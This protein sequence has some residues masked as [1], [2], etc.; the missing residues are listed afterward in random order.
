MLDFPLRRMRSFSI[1]TCFSD[2]AIN[3]ALR[4]LTGYLRPTPMYNFPI[5]A[6]IKPAELRRKGA[7]LS[8]AQGS[9]SLDIC[10]TQHSPA[11]RVGMHGITNRDTHFYPPHNN[12]SVHLTTTSEVRRSGW[13]TDGMRSGWTTPRE[14]ALS[15]PTPT[16]LEWPSEEQRG[17]SLSA[18]APESDISSPACTTGVLRPLR[19]VNVVQKNKPSTMLYSNVQSIDPLMDCTAWRFWMMR[20]S[21]SCSPLPRDIVRPSSGQQQLAQT[22]KK[23]KLTTNVRTIRYS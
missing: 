14:P 5:L 1:M 7:I 17:S 20:Q 15:S 21:N 16:L 19:P 11:H 22:T 6:G 10:S 12:S 2:P 9:W 18:S 8:L 4:M 3:D 13:T 23:C